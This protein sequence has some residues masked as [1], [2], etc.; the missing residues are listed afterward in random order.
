MTTKNPLPDC[1]NCNVAP[2]PFRDAVGMHAV[3]CDFCGLQTGQH[4]TFVGAAD[5]WRDIVRSIKTEGGKP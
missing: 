5:E 1:P 2:V 3:V 4:T